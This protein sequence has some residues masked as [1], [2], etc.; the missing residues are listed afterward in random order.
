MPRKPVVIFALDHMCALLLGSQEHNWLVHE[1]HVRGL[2][3]D[4]RLVVPRRC[5][6]ESYTGT[7]LATLFRFGKQPRPA[8]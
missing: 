4:A 2:G 1:S 3:N 8:E 7:T 5:S 6:S